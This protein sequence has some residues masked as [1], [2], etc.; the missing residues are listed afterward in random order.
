MK[1]RTP[2][3][4]RSGSSGPASACVYGRQPVQEALRAGRRRLIRLHVQDSLRESED[5][6]GLIAAARAAGA[7]VEF[8]DRRQLDKLAQGG[9]HQGVLLESGGYPYAELNAL[10]AR[11]EGTRDSLWLILDH[12]QD[13]HNVGALLRSAD[14]VGVAGVLIPVDRAV[15]VTDAVVRASAGAAEHVPVA[16][17][18]NLVRAMKTLQEH[19]V[20]MYG[21]DAAAESSLY[22]KADYKGGVGLVLGSEGTGLGRLV[23]ETCDFRIRIPLHGRVDS[24]N[25]SVAGAVAMYEVLRQRTL[26]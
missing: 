24:L 14:A 18:T 19:G 11:A 15:D 17:V 7:E 12:L 20:W 3:S 22:T 4:D 23:R 8:S 1:A 10:M 2:P 21:L 25:V 9:H 16:R 26:A 13:P 5:L 6:H